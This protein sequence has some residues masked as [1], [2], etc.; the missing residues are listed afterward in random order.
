MRKNKVTMHQAIFYQLYQARK[1]NPE[2]YIPIWKLIGEVYIEELGKWGFV[3]YEVSPIM[4]EIYRLNPN[5]L[6]RR[7]TTGKSGSK[8][9]EYRFSLNVSGEM[10]K[11]EKLLEFYK[12]L[13][14]R[15]IQ[16]LP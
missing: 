7:I 1:E 10:I 3:S 4:S 14:A 5:M 13:K 11:D 8:Y 9:Y 12:I 15:Q 16:L 2:Q 6:E